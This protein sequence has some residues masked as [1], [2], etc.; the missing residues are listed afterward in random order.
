MSDGLDPTLLMEMIILLRTK[1]VN[2]KT[3]P[4]LLKMSIAQAQAG[5]DIIGPSDMMDGELDIGEG[6]DEKG[7]RIPASCLIL[8]NMPCILRHLETLSSATW[9]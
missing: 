1:I 4:I 7:Y 6:L 5:V 2:D 3:L 8:L 9:R